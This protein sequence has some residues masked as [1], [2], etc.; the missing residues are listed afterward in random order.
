VDRY[1]KCL[2]TEDRVG[3]KGCNVESKSLVKQK[4]GSLREISD[5]ATAVLGPEKDVY[6]L[7]REIL[8]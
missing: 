5:E 1:N 8:C 6:I 7:R 4:Y 3:G 2:C